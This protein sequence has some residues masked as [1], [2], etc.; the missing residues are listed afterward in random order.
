[1]KKSEGELLSSVCPKFER[2]VGILD[3]EMNQ[4][5][6]DLVLACIPGW[7]RYD[8]CTCHSCVYSCIVISGYGVRQF[9]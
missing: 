5:E 1:M 8:D 4:Y 7:N 9:G 2:L 6:R 3:S